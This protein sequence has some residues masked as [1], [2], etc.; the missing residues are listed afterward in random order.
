MGIQLKVDDETLP[1][2]AQFFGMG[3]ASD[4]SVMAPDASG[5]A[6]PLPSSPGNPEVTHDPQPTKL[7]AL[8]QLLNTS[9]AAASAAAPAASGPGGP[10]AFEGI[11]VQPDTQP[12]PPAGPIASR[13]LSHA[14]DQG[15]IISP[16]EAGASPRQPQDL[17]ALFNADANPSVVKPTFQGTHPKVAATLGNILEFLQNAGPGIGAKTF[18][19]GFSIAAAQPALRAQRQNEVK[20]SALETLLTQGQVQDMPLNRRLKE[21]ELN[22]KLADAYKKFHPDVKA[23][24][25]NFSQGVPVSITHGDSEY[26][27]G[28]PN[29]PAEL[30]PLADAANA[31]YKQHLQ[32]QQDKP[33]TA[34]QDKQ[35]G[36]ELEVKLKSGTLSSDE[37]DELTT[38]QQAEKLQGVPSEIV[39]QV[40]HPPVPAQFAKGK[41]DPD[42]LAADKAWGNQV[43][44]IKAREAGAGANARG[45]AY[46][47]FKPVQVIDPATGELRWQY[48]R[49]AI[50]SG[51]APA[52][53]GTKAM[54]QQQQFKEMSFASSKARDAINNL[55]KDFTAPQIAKLTLA[56]SHSDPTVVS[57]E[58]NTIL[59][60]QQ[61]TPKQ[62]DFVVWLQQLNERALSLRNVAG[63][64]QGA[65]D[66]RSAIQATLPSVRSGGKSMALKQLDAFDNQVS[67]LQQGIPKVRGAGSGSTSGNGASLVGPIQTG[68]PTATGPGGHTIVFRSNKWIDPKN[69]QE[70]K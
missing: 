8:A 31:A 37:R 23:P 26:V 15:Q 21:A 41:S 19:E 2:I 28:G 30:K 11:G 50:S 52:A 33:D 40:G 54:S 6:M 16:A 34:Q 43:E 10:Q 60:T 57:N 47:E 24:K 63:M 12:L 61:L 9:P 18:G 44:Q 27:I 68:E 36:R 7:D 56:F 49:D 25:I 3:Q 48:A 45:Q 46:G 53:G 38:R 22:E 35:R 62:E 42:F 13:D 1:A 65:Q 32:D 29:M 66:L 58:I 59:G 39:S 20:R 17:A 55:D 4:N 51:A 67:L 5:N 70:A 69:G 64:G 14:F